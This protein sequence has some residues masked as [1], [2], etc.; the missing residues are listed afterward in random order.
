MKVVGTV[1]RILLGLIFAFFGFNHLY[2]FIPMGPMPVGTAGQ[3]MGAMMTSHYFFIVGLCEVIPG[4]LLLFNRYV[5]LA[6]VILGAV[7]FNI[8]LTGI[9]MAPMGLPSGAVAAI[10]WL[11]VYWRHRSAFAGIYQARTE[12]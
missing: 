8:L 1:A 5:P 12:G 6:L 7:I 3:F 10:L 2:P 4:L 11:I 9:L